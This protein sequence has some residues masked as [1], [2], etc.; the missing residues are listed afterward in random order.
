MDMLATAFKATKIYR[1]KAAI[2]DVRMRQ[3]KRKLRILRE[4]V[5]ANPADK[6]S[7]H[8]YHELDK[9]RLEY[10]LGEYKERAEFMPTEMAIKYELGVR[11]YESKHYDEAIAS[12]QEAQVNP[13]HR[14]EALH[15]LGRSF[16]H[17]NMKPEAVDTLKRSI[18]EYD[19]ASTGNAKS[20]DLH[21]W[22]ARA[23][24][25]NKQTNEAIDIY[26]KIVRWNMQYLDARKRLND[27][28]EKSG[29]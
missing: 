14:V 15:L 24:E 29:G 20:L 4:A 11:Q 5:K 16:L 22:Y 27:L 23:L 28:R 9:Q 8:Q 12:L 26:S 21:Y 6:D 13:K 25:E 18:D 10:E 19:L 7:L 2:G 17:Q 3:Y 1:L